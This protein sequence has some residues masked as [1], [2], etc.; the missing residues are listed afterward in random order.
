MKSARSIILFLLI[1]ILVGQ[2]KGSRSGLP[3]DMA[4]DR[5]AAVDI[6]VGEGRLYW[7]VTWQGL[8]ST[9]HVSQGGNGVT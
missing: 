3:L 1:H 9:I 2:I 8:C 6:G 7:S 4:M 5:D